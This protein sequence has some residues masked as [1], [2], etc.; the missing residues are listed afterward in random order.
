METGPAQ[1]LSTGR[2]LSNGGAASVAL[3]NIATCEEG[4]ERNRRALDRHTLR[5]TGYASGLSVSGLLTGV[6][7]R[8]T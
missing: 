8:P 7:W 2:G 5:A 1:W 3:S 6:D 4:H